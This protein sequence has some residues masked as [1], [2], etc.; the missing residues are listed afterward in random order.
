MI[1]SMK[2]RHYTDL[3]SN[4]PKFPVGCRSLQPCVLLAFDKG[5]GIDQRE[6]RMSCLIPTVFAFQTMRH[7][8]Q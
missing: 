8:D 5:R 6:M 3:N 7:A 1:D 2:Y 4:T